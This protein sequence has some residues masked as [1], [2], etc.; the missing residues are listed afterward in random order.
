V[1]LALLSVSLVFV[2][3]VRFLGYFEYLHFRKRQRA[4]LRD[5]F[6]ENLRRVVPR[7]IVSLSKA[8]TEDGALN[9]LER[10]TTETPML[11]VE[12]LAPPEAESPS[13]L[14][15]AAIA[16]CTRRDLAEIV[17]PIGPESSAIASLRFRFN[18]DME[19]PAPQV[20]MLL[21]ILVDELSGVLLAFGSG[22]LPA[23]ER[24]Q[25]EFPTERVAIAG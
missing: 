1:G 8:S 16:D 11:C 12:V 3:F 2:G 13:R 24:T 21:Q 14:W 19:D 20:E 5:P 10:L 18:C 6:T 23:P 15:S 22:L 17:F 4:R 25:S 7:L 9:I